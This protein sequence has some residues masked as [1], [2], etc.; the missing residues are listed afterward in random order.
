MHGGKYKGENGGGMGNG[1]EGD[2]SGGMVVRK[3]GTEDAAVQTKSNMDD[4]S[5]YIC[6]MEWKG[7]S[8]F[9]RCLSHQ[10]EWFVFD[11]IFLP[12]CSQSCSK[13][14]TCSKAKKN[15][16][17]CP[18]C[19]KGNSQLHYVNSMPWVVAYLDLKFFLPTARNATFSLH[20][21]IHLDHFSLRKFMDLRPIRLWIPIRRSK[22]EAEIIFWEISWN[23]EHPTPA[24]GAAWE[25]LR[26]LL[27]TEWLCLK[28][29]MFPG[30]CSFRALDVLSE[31][32]REQFHE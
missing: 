10:I 7:R 18:S 13:C 21:P 6:F 26:S 16:R 28:P 25:T 23:W 12:Q 27:S 14:W 2:S 31:H 17:K 9:L 11:I 29:S 32:N 1:E 30:T 3:K 8:L 22:L 15:P 5:L 19:S 4:K 20:V 24:C